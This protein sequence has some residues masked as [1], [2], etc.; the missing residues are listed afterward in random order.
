MLHLKLY[1]GEHIT[2][3]PMRIGKRSGGDIYINHG[4]VMVDI[5]MGRASRV[6]IDAPKNIPVVRSDAKSKEAV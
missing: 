4:G 5:G 2:I 6:S 1:P 3:G